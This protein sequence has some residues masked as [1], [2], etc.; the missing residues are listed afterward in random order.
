MMGLP[1]DAL[2]N[3]TDKAYEMAIFQIREGLEKR[4]LISTAPALR[5]K[6]KTKN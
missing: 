2:L 1:D 6:S 3:E 4:V 5:S